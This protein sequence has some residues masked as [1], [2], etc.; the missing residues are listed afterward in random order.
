MALLG[1]MAILVTGC[2][3]NRDIILPHRVNSPILDYPPEAI[4]KRESGELEVLL[5]LQEDGS[6]DEMKIHRSTGV[7]I[8]DEAGMEL[9]KSLEFLP[10]V[11]NGRKQ[12]C[13]VEQTVVFSLGKPP[14]S[15]VQWRRTTR[16][17]IQDLEKA[18]PAEQAGIRHRLYSQCTDYMSYVIIHQDLTINRMAIGLT[19]PTLREKWAQYTDTFPM[20][21][22][23]FADY[24]VRI[25]DPPYHERALVQLKRSVEVDILLIEK[26]LRSRE[27]PALLHLRENLRIFLAELQ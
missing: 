11:A 12:P 23:M 3:T 15:P 17:L 27:N 10:L 26:H 8:L 1:I 19:V 21:F 5:H 20:S 6:V 2:A 25:E 24:A 9:V 16:S 18:N 22:L 13:W 7:P 4:L 14:L